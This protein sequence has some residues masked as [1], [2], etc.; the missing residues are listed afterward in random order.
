MSLSRLQVLTPATDLALL[1]AAELRAA[2][3]L[4]AGNTTHDTQLAAL[5]LEAAEWIAADILDI[6]SAGG[7]VPTVLAEEL[8]ETFAPAY[9]G[10]ELVLARRFLSDVTVSENGVALVEDTDFVVHD[11]RGVLE[12]V[13]SGYRAAWAVAPIVVEYTAG[14]ENGS[15]SSVPPAIRA[16][17]SDYV[18]LRYSIA[19][20]DPMV[21]SETV[22][23]I[24]SV[25]YRDSS[26]SHGTFAEAA[27]QRLSRYIAGTAG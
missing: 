17:A 6:R 24:D 19:G 14:F 25:T 20:R 5:G 7:R 16:V 11:D 21:R 4:A 27:R 22:D 2:A 9:R 8:R 26:D 3:G 18:G 15:P 10:C 1:T 23:D 12:R 13:S